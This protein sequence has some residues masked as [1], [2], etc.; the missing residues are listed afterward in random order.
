MISPEGFITISVPSL[1][2]VAGIPKHFESVSNSAGSS[3]T[4]GTTIGGSTTGGTTTTG[5]S[6]GSIG[7]GCG[8]GGTMIAVDRVFAM[9]ARSLLRQISMI[10]STLV[11]LNS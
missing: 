3:T 10:A 1:V 4:G 5:G 6:T 8:F 11:S 9:R 2:K 7:P